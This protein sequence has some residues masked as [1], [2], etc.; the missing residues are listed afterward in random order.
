M[1]KLTIWLD[2]KFRETTPTLL[3]SL[4]PGILK[5][6]GV[7]ETM[8]VSNGKIDLLK[9][10]LQRMSRGLKVLKMGTAPF[11][12]K[13]LS[14]LMRQLLRVNRLKDARVRLMVWKEGRG[15]HRAIVVQPLEKLT[16]AQYRR[17]FSVL[18]MKGHRRQTPVPVKSLDYAIFREGLRKA[19]EGGFDEALFVNHKSELVE[20]SR[21]N[22]F[23]V[24]D[25]CIF[26]PPITSGCLSGIM[27]QQV[28]SAARR[29]KLRCAVRPLTAADLFAA[30]E[31]LLTNAL[32]GIMPLTRLDKQKIST[33]KPGP[34]TIRFSKKFRI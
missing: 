19:R 33:G 31:A 28:I 22:I 3:R 7:F 29:L 23:L 9:A 20:G 34:V 30:D 26:T 14:P 8:R 21:T 5:A 15:L 2:D 11:K 16:A 17:G 10:H 4:A 1:R 13:A 25:N 6:K 32:L 27:R 12:K 24:K 18:L